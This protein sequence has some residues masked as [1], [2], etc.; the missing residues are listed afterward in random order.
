M[1]AETAA[2]LQIM[3]TKLENWFKRSNLTICTK[4]TETLI[5]NYDG[6]PENYPKSII[7]INGMNIKNTDIFK[8]LGVK[9]DHDDYKTG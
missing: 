5:I 4:K 9:I 3:A 8:Y 2:E 6:D 7:T 1:M